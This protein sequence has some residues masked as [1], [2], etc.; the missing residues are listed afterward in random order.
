MMRIGAVI[1]PL[2]RLGNVLIFNVHLLS[3]TIYCTD[4]RRE[5]T[6]PNLI[7]NKNHF[8]LNCRSEQLSISKLIS[9]RF[10][11]QILNKRLSGLRV[12]CSKMFLF[13][14]FVTFVT[15]AIIFWYVSRIRLM[16]LLRDS[17]IPGPKPHLIFGHMNE[18]NSTPN[19]IWDSRMIDK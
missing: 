15:M 14:V 5:F 12:I 10:R 13:V 11:Y 8:H 6:Y 17:N 1:I 19:V 9:F 2:R 18:Y 7:L 16:R 3:I 4:D